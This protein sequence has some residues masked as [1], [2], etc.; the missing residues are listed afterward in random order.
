MSRITR[1]NCEPD[2]NHDFLLLPDVGDRRQQ[3]LGHINDPNAMTLHD[4]V[5]SY[6]HDTLKWIPSE[7]PANPTQWCG[8]GLNWHG[9]TAISGD[10]AHVASRVFTAWAEIFAIGPPKIMMTGQFTWIEG[11]SPESGSYDEIAVDRSEIVSKCRAIAELAAQ[12][13]VPGHWLL[14]VG[15]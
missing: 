11:D 3:Y 2:M 4:D 6:F 5:L 9:V 13:E 1:A 14:H 10:G 15:I 8:R 7:N 12:A